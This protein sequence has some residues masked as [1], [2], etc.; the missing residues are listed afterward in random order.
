M[1]T[2]NDL[3]GMLFVTA[4]AG[5]AVYALVGPEGREHPTTDTETACDGVPCAG[6]VRE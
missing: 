4:L 1:P 3:L 5:A 6:A 2:W